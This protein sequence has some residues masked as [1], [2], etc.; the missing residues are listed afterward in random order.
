MTTLIILLFITLTFTTPASVIATWCMDLPRGCQCGARDAVTCRGYFTRIPTNL[1]SQIHE[2]ILQH[3]EI[4]EIGSSDLEQLRQLKVLDLSNNRINKIGQNVFL[5][6]ENLESLNLER[7]HINWL[8]S[9]AFRGLQRLRHLY[10]D[11][12][13]IGILPMGLFAEMSYLHE[14]R[15]NNNGLHD[16]PKHTADELSKT[17]VKLV[18]LDHNPLHCSC[19]LLLFSHW[20]KQSTDVILLKPDSVRCT[21]DNEIDKYKVVDLVE[22]DVMCAPSL[23]PKI[24]DIETISCDSVR[25]SWDYPMSYTRSK[26]QTKASISFDTVIKK[27][28]LFNVMVKV[29]DTHEA[30]R[31]PHVFMESD[32]TAVINGLD[33]SIE[34][35]FTVQAMNEVGRGP[36]SDVRKYRISIFKSGEQVVSCLEEPEEE[37]D[38]DQPPH[39]TLIDETIREE[40]D[41]RMIIITVSCL[42]GAVV[43][44]IV[45]A[46]FFV[47]VYQPRRNGF[48]PFSSVKF[49]KCEMP[50]MTYDDEVTSSSVES[51]DKYRNYTT[52]MIEGLPTV[53][54]LTETPR[55]TVHFIREI[56]CGRFGRIYE[57]VVTELL[58]TEKQTVTMVKELREN[59]TEHARQSFDGQVS[60]LC[61][62]EHPNVL[63]M[64]GVV[65]IGEPLS[66][67]Y[68]YADCGDLKEFLNCNS[69]FNKTKSATNSLIL[70][71]DKLVD[72]ATQVACAMSYLSASGFVHR[73]LA[74]H[75][76]M[77]SSD[78]TVKV[79]DIGISKERYPMHY[80]RVGRKL[81]PVR[82]MAP[83]TLE[84]TTHFNAETDVW[85]Y[86]VTL[87]EIF[88]YGTLPFSCF[89][90][91][92]AVSHTLR[93]TLLPISDCL[94]KKVCDV[95]MACW[96]NNA[97]ERASF[98]DIHG[99]LSSCRLS[100]CE[101][102]IRV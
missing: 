32:E 94:P 90:D 99:S 3:N 49:S 51:V 54:I 30:S 78:L 24:L 71:Q 100:D 19:D 41:K 14:L 97:H 62:F 66:I 12:N 48:A 18:T 96:R 37:T 63:E 42:T 83:E 58:P 11:H 15:L 81:L 27:G 2:L 85:S 31:M 98:N 47:K 9:R 101:G 53:R 75:N 79:A 89:T 52:T 88:S 33:A 22:D 7:N 91:D 73:D 43:V 8:D 20:L 95:M 80:M 64:L 29:T 26:A 82:W 93:G 57:A 46:V 70:S 21:T 72:V 86:G 59:A 13:N 28:P 35:Q 50:P 40:K 74:A 5:T 10:L 68:E 1:P 38:V 77:V 102:E 76:C 92:Q 44:A 39:K 17:I 34:H 23:A 4:T 36:F 56:Y 16:V 45:L 67:I 6:L 87:W 55:D 25:I 60:T 84:S 61:E 65:T 69:P